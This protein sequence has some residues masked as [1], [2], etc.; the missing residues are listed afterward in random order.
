[1]TMR[2]CTA[3]LG[4]LVMTTAYA[5]E[6]DLRWDFAR[7]ADAPETVSAQISADGSA[8]AEPA[9]GKARR[10]TAT[11]R[12]ADDG[13]QFA[14]GSDA[15]NDTGVFLRVAS[16]PVLSGHDR[17]GGG[18]ISL[19]L[20]V[21]V[22]MESLGRP[23]SLLRKTQFA[24]E[25][26]YLLALSPDGQVRFAVGNWAGKASVSS[27]EMRL[28]AGRWHEVEGIWEDGELSLRIDN[29]PCGNQARLVGPLP[30]IDSPL[31][32]GAIDRG[33]G[34]T[35]Q[36]LDGTLRWARIR[37]TFSVRPTGDKAMAPDSDTTLWGVPVRHMWFCPPCQW[38]T[39]SRGIPLLKGVCHAPL[40]EPEQ[41]DGA[42]NHHPE[43]IRHRGRFHAMWSNNMVGEDRA[44]QRILYT[45]T[46]DPTR[47]PPPRLLFPQPGEFFDQLRPAVPEDA[48]RLGFYMTAMK[49]IPLGDRLFALASF[50]STR[51]HLVPLVR[52]LKA[53]GTRG[54]IFALHDTFDRSNE[55][56]FPFPFLLP[57]EEPER[58][59]AAELL[60]LYLTPRYLPSWDFGIEQWFHRPRS[61]EGTTLCEWSI[62]RAHDGRSVML[63]R[64]PRMSHRIYAGV[65]DSDDP[66]SF[67]PLEPTDIPDT[68]SKSVALTLASGTVLLIGNQ[69]AREFDN[70]EKPTH[71]DRD[72][73]TIS[74]STDGYRFERQIA[75][76]W[77]GGRLWRTE[78]RKV[79]GRGSG[80]QY[81]AA[82][83]DEGI[84]Y[85]I[86]SIG[87]EDVALSWVPLANLGVE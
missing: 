29:Q 74:I 31:A 69:I 2:L 6:T 48:N 56:S 37:G 42:Y 27:G 62:H 46:D 17:N 50:D 85:V 10:E 59:L 35:G 24:T 71:Y 65:S 43:I 4:L 3:L 47:W 5:L 36:F 9:A 86:Y 63:A 87:K 64:D 33:R 38:N 55:A 77:E 32:I 40:F 53:D 61:V 72:P 25:T 52:E 58:S 66:N 78:C 73:L 12:W 67:P 84:L 49:F 16:S 70:L 82:M 60:E 20:A 26:G 30:P 41:T 75:L 7:P 51:R 45:S 39:P 68:P 15:D 14:N 22:R 57:T 83:V 1:M 28:T 13:L 80:C 8:Q 81:P 34:S 23:Q 44:G 54:E 19:R 11:L 18:F 79:P 21:R 76:R